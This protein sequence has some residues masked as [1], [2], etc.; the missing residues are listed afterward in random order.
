MDLSQS[1]THVISIR[2]DIEHP[3]TIIDVDTVRQWLRQTMK[4]CGR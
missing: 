2:Q 1:I 3:I 4:E